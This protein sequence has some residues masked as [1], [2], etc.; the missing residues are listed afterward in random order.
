MIEGKLSPNRVLA[1]VGLG[2]MLSLLGDQT[3]YTV[4]PDPR[5]AAEAGLTL[6]MVGILLGANRLA[7][8]LT[9]A[10]AGYL[11][12]RFPRKPLMVFSL[13]IGALSTL[14]YI[15]APGP[16]VFVFGRLLWGMAWSG[17]WIGSNTIALDISEDGDRGWITGR[18]QMWF[19]LSIGIASLAG[20]LFT[21][22]FG[23]K[24]GLVLSACLTSLGVMLWALLLPET[25]PVKPANIGKE[26]KSEK[27]G[28]RFPWLAA[29][30][31]S[32]PVFALR[33]VFAGVITSTTILWL[34]QFV[35]GE[36]ALGEIV[37]PLATLTGAFVVLRVLLSMVSAPL[38][39]LISDRVGKRWIV[40]GLVLLVGAAGLWLMGSLVLA[41]ALFGAVLATVSAGGIQGLV[42][43][44]VGD[45]VSHARQS[46]VLGVVY[47]IGDIGSAIGPPMALFLVP[48]IGIGCLFRICAG[49]FGA[50]G[51][52]GLLMAGR[53]K[54]W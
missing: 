44:V 53:E 10:P 45:R 49:I 41:V 52:F 3:L 25:R 12:D 26:N 46:R 19:F 28:G 8:V 4:L 30:G 23:F 34:G 1:P 11:Y 42:P 16:A 38:S 18:L 20:G 9:N 5:I 54:Y 47:T 27:E 35:E 36:V 43:A 24:G 50:A 14:L 33:L 17:I 13:A 15:I 22:L 31:A 32:V 29:L 40:L 37:V 39:G 6:A 48:L 21:D 7:R 2:M 51:L